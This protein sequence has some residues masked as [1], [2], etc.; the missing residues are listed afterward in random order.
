MAEAAGAHH[1]LE[2]AVGGADHAHIDLDGAAAA[3]AFDLL[4]LQHPQ[5]PDLG[6]G[7]QLTDFVQEDRAPVGAFEAA[8]LLAQ[9]SGE[10]AFLVAEE[11]GVQQAVR[12][13]AAVDFDEAGLAA[14]REAVQGVGDDLL[15]HTGFPQQHDRA[16]QRRDLP[17][18]LQYA[19][20]A[21]VG[22][23]D[24]VAHRMLQLAAEF[25]VLEFE[26]VLESENLIIPQGV[27][28][29]DADGLAQQFQQSGVL[30]PKDLLAACGHT[31]GPQGDAVH[32]QYHAHDRGVA[33]GH[34]GHREL[35]DRI[36]F[37]L[38]D[39]P[40]LAPVVDVP[41][42]HRPQPGRGCD[43]RHAAAAALGV[44]HDQG[45]D[46]AQVGLET[47]EAEPFGRDVAAEIVQEI[48][49]GCGDVQ[50]AADLERGLAEEEV[51]VDVHAGLR[52]QSMFSEIAR[53]RDIWQ[54]RSRNVADV[55]GFSIECLDIKAMIA[56]RLSCL[57]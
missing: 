28:K 55:K 30:G 52:W 48:S 19:G 34:V 4:V 12:N 23:H 50:A 44:D 20:Q 54:V 10:G 40:D 15:A 32:D 37:G 27:R 26:H 13:G 14:W 5:Q 46:Q 57:T 18:H 56:W 35:G 22:A 38:V 3:Y 21:E 1:G 31:E 51:L 42:Q 25:A 33:D 36:E 11:L 41:G 9:G 17:D 6:L 39:D 43:R 16:R 2:V 47:A 24:L 49:Q 7:G 8:A 53:N 45:V 29:G